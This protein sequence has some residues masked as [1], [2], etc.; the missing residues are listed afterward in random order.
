VLKRKR[1]VPLGNGDYV[2]GYGNPPKH[3]QYRP[4]ESGNPAGRRKG[5][6]NLKTDVVRTL[7]T[8]VKVKE[9]GRTRTRSTQ[10]GALM[11]LR[12]KAL[13]GDA[14]ALDRIFELAL[15]FN[16]DTAE[17]GP[18]QPLAAEDQ[19]ILAAYVAEIGASAT[20]QVATKPLDDSS[21]K[22]AAKSARKAS[23]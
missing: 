20:A 4:G 19:A 5:I 6:H 2:V 10:E 16:N 17:I 11:L 12:E 15:R 14:R 23:K 18:A 22:P 1:T 8:P 7:A 9:G 21:P 3:S 13:R